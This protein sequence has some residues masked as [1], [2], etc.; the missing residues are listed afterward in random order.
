MNFA[1]ASFGIERFQ[2]EHLQHSVLQYYTS[3]G[4]SPTWYL[5]WLITGEIVFNIP[6]YSTK[7][8]HLSITS[9]YS[10]IHKIPFRCR[11][12]AACY[13]CSTFLFY[14]CYTIT[15]VHLGIPRTPQ[16]LLYLPP[17][18]NHPFLDAP[19]CSSAFSKALKISLTK[20]TPFTTSPTAMGT[21]DRTKR[22]KNGR[23]IGVVDFRSTTGL[24]RYVAFV[25]GGWRVTNR[26]EAKGTRARAM[27]REIDL[28]RLGRSGCFFHDVATDVHERLDVSLSI[29]DL[30][31][32]PDLGFQT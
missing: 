6:R 28:S 11:A 23:S 25:S 21:V 27:D 13:L 7:Y 1:T 16:K 24:R 17:S 4:V 8:W 10:S 22:S 3:F 20:S 9:I 31:L 5:F 32:P 30:D 29:L 2:L 12:A 19:R 18:L 14:Y 15:S 26:I